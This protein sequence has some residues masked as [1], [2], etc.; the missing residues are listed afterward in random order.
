MNMALAA[1]GFFSQLPRCIDHCAEEKHSMFQFGSY[2]LVTDVHHDRI[3]RIRSITCGITQTVA[4]R[5]QRA[6]FWLRSKGARL[7]TK[8]QRLPFRNNT[9]AG[10]ECHSL[11]LTLARMVTPFCSYCGSDDY[12]SCISAL[13]I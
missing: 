4:N 6:H 1:D 5:V 9:D 12:G 10:I 3:D 7:I 11:F 13:G 8:S 2:L